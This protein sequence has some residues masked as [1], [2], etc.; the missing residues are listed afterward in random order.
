MTGQSLF[1]LDV[2]LLRS[3]FWYLAGVGQTLFG[4]GGLDRRVFN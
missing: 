1:L 3:F 4:F 2:P